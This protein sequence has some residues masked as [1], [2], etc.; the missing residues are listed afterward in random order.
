MSAFEHKGEF[1]VEYGFGLPQKTTAQRQAYT[2]P[3]D[4]YQVF[5]TDIGKVFVYSNS[6]GWEEQAS[7][8]RLDQKV[9][10]TGDTMTGPLTLAGDPSNPLEA[11]PKQYVDTALSN[12]GGNISTDDLTD[13]DTTTSALANKQTLV[14]NGTNFV[15]RALTKD[16]V[17][18]FDDADYATAAQGTLADS[19]VQPND[20]IS[21]LNNDVGY[22]SNLNNES[23]DTLSDVDTTTTSPVNGHALVFDGTNFVN[24]E[25]TKNDVSDFDDSDYATSAQG[26]LADSAVQPND[27]VSTLTNDTGFISDITSESIG[28]LVDVNTTTTPTDGQ[29]LVWDNGASEFVPGTIDVSDRVAKAGDT[30]TGALTIE[31]NTINTPSMVLVSDVFDGPYEGASIEFKERTSGGGLTGTARIYLNGGDNLTIVHGNGVTQ[32]TSFGGH[33]ISATNGTST[34]TLRTGT[35][36]LV[37]EID[38]SDIFNFD[39][40]TAKFFTKVQSVVAT[41]SGDINSTLTTKGYVDSLVSTAGPESLDD[42]DDVDFSTL[43]S[44]GNAFVYDGNSFIARDL[45]KADVS[46]F[47]EADYVHKTG[48]ES[49]AGE[50]TFTDAVIM[51]SDLNVAGNLNVTGTVTTVNS[52]DT[53]LADNKITLNAGESGAGVTAVT[54]GFIVDRGTEDNVCFVFDESDDSWKVGDD[55]TLVNVST[56][57]RGSFVVGD[58][59]TSSGTSTLVIAQSEHKLAISD[60][61]DVTVFDG[62]RRV[63]IGYEVNDTTGD[64]TLT[65]KGATFGGKYRVAL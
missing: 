17:S 49:I 57:H 11:A 44:V 61:Y 58:W 42:L 40:N 16:D 50:K 37:Y 10:K 2:P 32:S 53:E 41:Q 38:N 9:N 43:P 59:T 45:T 47:S 13:V 48:N 33:V 29:T 3:R 20:D 18:D 51:S 65:T 34:G 7:A 39:A 52:T 24:R 27:N 15:N 35:S 28:D 26:T 56:V 54:S 4:G 5:D 64:I 60:I 30:M 25:L 8:A 23:I 55:T 22:L 36:A 31:L 19:A 62:N 46:D 63:G 6:N 1:Y 12:L 21:E 14:Y